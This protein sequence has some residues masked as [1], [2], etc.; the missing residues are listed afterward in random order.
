MY[1]KKIPEVTPYNEE[2]TFDPMFGF[3]NGRKERGNL[4]DPQLFLIA[5]ILNHIEQ[6]R[7]DDDDVL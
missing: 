7:M 1:E 6:Y 5:I 3:P 2:I 4:S